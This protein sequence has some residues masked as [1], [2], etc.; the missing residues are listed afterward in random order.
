MEI[1]I[2]AIICSTIIICVGLISI[3]LYVA[4]R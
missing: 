3:A 4:V 2:T 1:L